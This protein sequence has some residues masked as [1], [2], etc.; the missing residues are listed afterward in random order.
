MNHLQTAQSV[1]NEA[2]G[3]DS[4]RPGQEEIVDRLLAG[5][6]VLAVMPT[7]AGK[8]LCYQIPAIVRDG[9]TIV[10]SP[11]VALMNDQAAALEANGVAVACIHSGKSRE[12]NVMDWRNVQGGDVKIL[13]LSPERL[14]TE[15]ML[16]VLDAIKPGMFIVDEAHC[17]SKWGTG[18]RPDYAALEHLKAR[19]PDATIGGFTATADATTRSDIADKLFGGDG[20]TVVHGF[21]RPNIWL[22]VVPK[23]QWRN[24]LMEFLE[25]RRGQSGI[26]YCASRRLT[27][28]VASFLS[29][30]GI[31]GLPYHAGMSNEDRQQNQ[32]LFMSDEAI[33]MVATIAFGMGI[34]KSDI[35]FVFHLNLPGS[36]EAYYQEIGRAGRDGAPA[37]AFMIYGLDDIRTRRQFIE[38]DSSE[39]EYKRK[40]HK[41]LDTLLAYCE[42]TQCR[43][44][45][46][47]SYFGEEE[48][49]ACG[50]CD[51]CQN[52]PTLIDGTTEAQMLLSAVVRSGERF[53]ANHIID[54]LTGS[55]TERI[56]S[57]GHDKLPTFGVGNEHSKLFWR[58]F[59]RQAV[60]GG[61]L[62]IDIGRFGGLRLSRTGRL[63]L[64]G[65]QQFYYREISNPK[66]TS[67]SARS[68]SRTDD[69][70]DVDRELYQ[71]LKRL[72]RELADERNVPAYVIFADR[73]LQEITREKPGNLEQMSAVNGVGPKKLED[74][75][76]LFL[77]A[78]SDH[79]N[80]ADD[81][82][83][84]S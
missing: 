84:S 30:N 69:F 79:L 54:I 12:N 22:G 71:R 33:V 59:I 4:F 83:A 10:V 56:I 16:T 49:E 64:K 43:R 57:L 68:E 20:D 81:A 82:S 62:V 8:S 17:I 52:P 55:S 50:N 14:M 13:Y 67:R 2:F 65:A 45:L 46:L 15:R 36:M 42:A 47:L 80:A 3:F 28:E 63:V 40:E 39:E 32:E 58:A 41:R 6:N 77:D 75:G 25:T 23:T 74:F 76:K 72:R 70:S 26:V 9:L 18:F 73:T 44:V 34:D 1:L 29:E 53:G 24:Q 35:R 7:G 27:E 66:T 11:L 31:R 38:Q 60:A 37:D 51:V 21:D 61:Y 19:Y 48:A 5:R 78:V